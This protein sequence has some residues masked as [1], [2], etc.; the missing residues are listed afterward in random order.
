[1]AVPYKLLKTNG[2]IAHSRA[3]RAVIKEHET[4]GLKRIARL[5]EK[6]T[7]MTVADIVGT[8]D[9]LTYE[10]AEQLMQGNRVYLPGLGYFSLA[11]KG[12]L[13]ENPK[14]H[15]FRLRNPYVRTVNFRPEKGLMRT[16][17][18]TSFENVTYRTKPHALPTEAE[19]ETALKR[20]FAESVCIF[21]GDLRA[22]LHLSSTVAYR[23]ARR[24]EAEGRLRNIGSPY[25]KVFVDGKA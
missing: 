21:V 14:T 19:V 25:R 18:E 24:L 20:L 7:A 1:M 4:V 13:Y 11:V 6:A 3:F 10:L 17:R 9:A 15:K 22:E 12:E 5:I 23:L 8:L 16:L 2:R